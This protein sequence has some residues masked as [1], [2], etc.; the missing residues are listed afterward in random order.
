MFGNPI[1]GFISPAGTPFKI[2]RFRVTSSFADH[3]AS[4]RGEGVDI[5]NGRCG[6]PVLAM[7]D[8]KV[9]FAGPDGKALVVRIDHPQFPGHQTGYAHLAQIDTV[10]HKEV[11]RGDRIGLLGRT[12]ADACHLHIGLKLRGKEIDSWPLLDQNA[13]GSDMLK[14]TLI[15]RIHN[16]RTKMLG[17]GTRL[18][19]SP[20]TAERELVKLAAG[21]EF[22][23]HFVVE[24]GLANG[25]RRWLAGWAT[26][27]RGTEFGYISE[28]VLAPLKPIEGG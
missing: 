12:G 16:R 2:D 15:S 22:F 14:G 9:A 27:P 1:A 19:P 11:R 10:L 20:G 5:G 17:N 26:T 3:V 25:S 7:A 24:G 8:G 4:H 18:R 6:A 28:T 21:M 23:P 13:V